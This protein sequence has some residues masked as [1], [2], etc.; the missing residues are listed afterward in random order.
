[1]LNLLV[2]IDVRPKLDAFRW[3]DNRRYLD[4]YEGRL[5]VS[6]TG[7]SAATSYMSTFGVFFGVRSKW[8]HLFRRPVQMISSF[9]A[10][11][12]NGLIFFGVRSFFRIL[13]NISICS[14]L[15]PL[16]GPSSQSALALLFLHVLNL[17]LLHTLL[18]AHLWKHIM[19]DSLHRRNIPIHWILG[20][21]YLG[22]PNMCRP[23]RFMYLS[24][25][26]LF[27]PNSWLNLHRNDI[28]SL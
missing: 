5:K 12:P 7:S 10:S 6:T 27:I 26:S 15:Q 19:N 17:N 23:S 14:F 22:N 4:E 2:N 11:I 28:V 24:R 21:N 8:S 20:L 13:L 16:H 9:S 25:D 3:Y 1:M 18:N